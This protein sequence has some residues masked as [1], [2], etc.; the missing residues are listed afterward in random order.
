M[1]DEDSIEHRKRKH[2]VGTNRHLV[3]WLWED[4]KRIPKAREDITRWSEYMANEMSNPAFEVFINMA[5]NLRNNKKHSTR[6]Q[7]G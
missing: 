4:P 2:N 6:A 3:Q 7:D 1:V 5:T